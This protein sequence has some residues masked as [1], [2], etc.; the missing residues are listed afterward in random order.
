SKWMFKKDNILI[1]I[2]IL[3]LLWMFVI[4]GN[5]FAIEAGFA[6]RWGNLLDKTI[7]KPFRL[8]DGTAWRGV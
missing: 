1:S 2:L 5:N 7:K 3:K 8:K 4:G 6:I